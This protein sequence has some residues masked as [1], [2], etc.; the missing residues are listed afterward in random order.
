M[1]ASTLHIVTY[2]S[3]PA[4]AEVLSHRL[5][6]RAGYIF[7][8]SSGLYVYSPLMW[9]V[10]R[11]IEG[12]VRESLDAA[13]AREVQVPIL[14]DRELWEE[15]GRWDLYM[16]SGTLFTTTDRR[17]VTFGLAPTAE[18]VVTAYVRD[19]VSSYKQLPL[20][21]YQIHTKFRDE[22]RPR[23]GLMR[24]KEFLMKDAYSFDA[25]EEGLDRSFQAMREA[26][27]RLFLKL[28]LQTLGVEADP[29]AIGGTG[30]MEFM[31]TADTGE[32]AILVEPSGTYGANE[33]KATSLLGPPPGGDEAPRP[34]RI[35][36]TPDIRTCE[37]LEAFFPDVPIFRMVKTL[38]YKSLSPD[39]ERLWA[40]LIRGDRQVNEVKLGNFTGGLKL[41]MLTAGEIEAL[42]GAEQGFAGPIGLPPAF[43]LAADESVR[44]MRNILCGLNRTDAHALD[45]QIGRDFPAPAF[46]DFRLAEEGEPGPVTGE[47]LRRRRGIEVGHIFKLGTKYSAAMQALFTDRDGKEKPFEMGCYGIGISRVAAAAVEQ[48]ADDRGIVWPVPIAPFEVVVTCLLD[49]DPALM[50]LTESLY[51]QLRDAGADVLIDDRSLSPG[52]R[53][54]DLELLGFPYVVLMGKSFRKK[55]KVELR[56]RRGMGVD[57]IDPGEVASVL[58]EKILRERRGRLNG[59]GL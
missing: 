49:D 30:S 47:P 51:G 15:S 59:A 11:K 55:G 33:E 16:A 38:F 10:L 52:A 21:L 1:R 56:T 28:G 37:Q 4:E 44:G 23:F 12:I 32:D 42:T 46:A 45:V 2:R 43:H 58:K 53:L 48:Y 41:E 26:Y 54:K 29:G 7:K 8:V 17:G 27:T 9:R 24:V 40:V 25:D 57:F 18:E 22:I 13:G 19:T 39:E 6:A 34:M 35:E 50:E 14:Q 3:D 31:V 36:E 20:N 5:M